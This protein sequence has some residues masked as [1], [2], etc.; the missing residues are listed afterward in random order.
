[1][2]ARDPRDVLTRTAPGPDRVLSYG[3]NADQVIDLRLPGG[4]IV[5]AGPRPLVVVVHG[6]F[7]RAAYDR[8]HAG[9]Q[10]AALAAE[11]YVVAV[12]EYRRVGGRD[13]GWPG[14]FDDTAAWNDRLLDLIVEEMGPDAIDVDRVVLLG[15]SAG[16][17]LALWS[18]SRHLL[19]ATSRW[20]RSTP[21][22]LRGVITLAAVA[23]LTLAAELGLDD[24]ATAALMGGGPDV[25]PD[26][27][28]QA[29]PARLLP[30]GT[31]TVLVHGRADENVPVEQSRDYAR[32][33]RAA[34]AEIEVLELEGTGHFELIDPLSAA[35]PTV[36]GALRTVLG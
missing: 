7:W 6:G 34:D 17:H 3:P 8:A 35:W 23:N 21:L 20:H 2:S 1:M 31:P 19:P 15:H 30:S 29:D 13:G 28:L 5:T 16:G 36:I 18:A 24:D 9:P 27:Y 22:A 10:A 32:R 25:E 11:G 4:T 26:R 14:T 12:P 33:A